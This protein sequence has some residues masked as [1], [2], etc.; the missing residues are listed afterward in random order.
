MCWSHLPYTGRRSHSKK[1]CGCVQDPSDHALLPR[2]AG[3]F[4]FVGKTTGRE[5]A[6]RRGRKTTVI[7]RV[8]RNMHP[9]RDRGT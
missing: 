3:V 8:D 6:S 2:D 1:G 4:V 5:D 7:S 9:F